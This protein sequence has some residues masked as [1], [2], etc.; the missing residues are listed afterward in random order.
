MDTIRNGVGQRKVEDGGEVDGDCV[1][2]GKDEDGGWNEEFDLFL[3]FVRSE[4]K[5]KSRTGRASEMSG[6]GL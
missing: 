2:V 5:C 3:P 6:G 1:H 4:A